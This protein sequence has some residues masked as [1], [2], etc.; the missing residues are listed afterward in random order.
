MNL[1]R[2]LTGISISL[3]LYAS[4]LNASP[5]FYV[6]S[7][8]ST[9]VQVIDQATGTVTATVSVA[10]KPVKVVAIADRNVVFVAD[11]SGQVNVVDT[12]SNTIIF[13]IPLDG[14]PCD[15]AL[16]SDGQF[17]YA[18]TVNGILSAIQTGTYAT[19]QTISSLGFD[20]RATISPT[21]N[22]LCVSNKV[23]GVVF[24]YN[25]DPVSSQFVLT[26]TLTAGLHSPREIVFKPDGTIFYVFNTSNNSI[27]V[28]DANALAA[29]KTVCL[30]AKPLAVAVAPDGT[31]IYVAT[32]G[33]E[34]SYSSGNVFVVNPTTFSISAPIKVGASPH[35]I[36]ADGT[37]VYVTDESDVNVTLINTATLSVSSVINI[38]HASDSIAL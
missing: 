31:S 28:V 12:T 25:Q 18:L 23:L 20:S 16:S 30:G 5:F 32:D 19:V 22:Q 36:T 37:T 11:T 35:G 27:L 17:L 1:M 10:A 26:T 8:D 7:T 13:S 6:C 34:C 24:V 15:L 14:I 21:G 3:F 29:I 2:I 4:G 33:S 38:G 9:D